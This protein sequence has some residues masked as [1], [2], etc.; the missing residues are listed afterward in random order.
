ML[1][2]TAKEIM[3]EMDELKDAM[4][5]LVS[6][7]EFLTMEPEALVILQKCISLY[8]KSKNFMMKTAAITDEMNHKLDK[9][10]EL[11]EERA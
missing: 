10:L 4:L 11:L 6:V 1:K 5:K 7:D 2:D 9:V 8:E 3:N